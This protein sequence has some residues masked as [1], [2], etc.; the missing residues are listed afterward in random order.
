MGKTSHNAHLM[1]IYRRVLLQIN[2]Q[3]H[4]IK[5]R[6]VPWRECWHNVREGQLFAETISIPPLMSRATKRYVAHVL[7]VSRDIPPEAILQ[8][9]TGSETSSF[10]YFHALPLVDIPLLSEHK[11]P[12]VFLFYS[13]HSNRQFK[14]HLRNKRLIKSKSTN[15]HYYNGFQREEWRTNSPACKRCDHSEQMKRNIDLRAT[16][17]RRRTT[18][19]CVLRR[20]EHNK[21]N[22]INRNKLKLAMNLKSWRRSHHSY[23]R[24]FANISSGCNFSKSFASNMRWKLSAKFSFQEAPI[25]YRIS[26]DSTDLKKCVNATQLLKY[27][28]VNKREQ[29]KTQVWQ[30]KKKIKK[31]TNKSRGTDKRHTNRN[32]WNTFRVGRTKWNLKMWKRKK[33]RKIRQSKYLLK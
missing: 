14:R 21:T 6:C 18:M 31:N 23:D 12:F 3:Y 29:I 33:K 5:R 9:M 25:K 30:K 16:R 20:W 28:R 11:T 2:F 4:C 32:D 1:E 10:P 24:P 22:R 8:E 7:N 27:K 26:S 15:K 19:V 13:Q 17:L